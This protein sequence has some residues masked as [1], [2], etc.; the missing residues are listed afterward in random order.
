MKALIQKQNRAVIIYSTLAGILFTI[1]RT[2]LFPQIGLATIVPSLTYLVVYLPFI[3][4]LWVGFFLGLLVDLI[5]NSFFG[6]FAL[7]YPLS[8]AVIYR[9]KRFFS[10]STFQMGLFFLFASLVLTLIHTLCGALFF[11]KISWSFI[12]I[13]SDFV[14]MPLLDG[15]YGVLCFV[16]P[17]KALKQLQY[18]LYRFKLTRKW[19]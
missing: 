12:A 19:K 14:I 7:I 6:F 4:S 18:L 1:C 13:F 2:A 17:I 5:S 11:K 3:P 10:D 9:Y 16:L 15:L 8:I